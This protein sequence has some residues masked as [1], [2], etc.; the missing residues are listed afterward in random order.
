MFS[1]LSGL[2]GVD[3]VRALAPQVDTAR[4]HGVPNGC[5]LELDLQTVPPETAG[6]DPC[7]ASGI[8]GHKAAAAAGGGRGDPPRRRGRRGWRG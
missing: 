7:P 1:L 4:H 6:F 2:P 5:I 3:D 8:T